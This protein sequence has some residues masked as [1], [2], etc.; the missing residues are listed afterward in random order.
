MLFVM[1]NGSISLLYGPSTML[2]LLQ[3]GTNSAVP[4]DKPRDSR[5][6]V[7]LR[8]PFLK[9]WSK[10]DPGKDGVRK[11]SC[12]SYFS[13]FLPFVQHS[14]FRDWKLILSNRLCKHSL[15]PSSKILYCSLSR[16][17]KPATPSISEPSV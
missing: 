6:K 10:R 2:N 13:T 8:P 3:V 9:P 16:T 5:Y 14:L 1:K 12:F 4:R 17:A 11:P 7:S 15:A